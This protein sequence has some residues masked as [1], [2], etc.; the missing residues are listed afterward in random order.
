[1]SRNGTGT[2]NLPAGNPVSTGTTISSSWANSTLSDIGS[3]LTGSIA[4]DGQTTPTANLPMGTYAHTGVGNATARTMY[5]SAGQVQDSTFTYLTSVA[6]TNAI[7]ASAPVVMTAYATGQI[8]RFVAAG[9]STGAVTININ[10]IGLKS[11]VRTDGS[12]LVSGDIASGAAVQIMYDGTNF[13]LISDANGKSESV[14]NLTVTGTLT[15]SNDATINGLKIGK[16]NNGAPNLGFGNTALGIQVL[17]ANTDG[18]LNTAI[19]YQALQSNTLGTANT[20]IGYGPL[21][22]N[23]TGSF[24][25]ALGNGALGSNTSGGNNISIGANSLFANTTGSSNVAMGNNALR[26]NTTGGTNIALGPN[27]LFVNTTG[28]NNIALGSTSLYSNTTSS[29]NLALGNSALY[30][31]T[32]GPANI[33]LGPNAL[34][35]NTSGG[36]NIAL[37]QNALSGNISGYSNLAFG[38]SALTTNTTGG[39]NVA[40]GSGALNLNTTGSNNVA[41]GADALKNNTTGIS[42]IAIQPINSTGVYAPVFDP[43]TENNRI[44]LGST[45]VTNA[46]VQVAWTVVSDARDKTDFA[47]VPHGLDFVT[48]LKPTAYRYKMNR[49]DTEG[50]GVV[51]YGF[52][53]QDVLELEGDTPVIVDAEDA[54]KLRFNDQSMLAVLVNA[55][56][57]LNAKFEEY[58]ASHP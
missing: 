14:T 44:C 17:N 39:A 22:L 19:G 24:N 16:G 48:K 29:D 23:T 21:K 3:A 41:L 12:A 5:A 51:R 26:N 10:S 40:L 45:A 53:A 50:H 11:V 55:I 38:L 8:F 37:G 1:M 49:E 7:T 35:Y 32:I 46:Y 13:Q 18:T 58:K 20:A 27:S 33:A 56:Q 36:Y 25:T 47:S 15:A 2:Y 6:G 42:N 57:E 34:R 52:K 43:T 28:A 31:N 30:D 54:E 4:S 9:A